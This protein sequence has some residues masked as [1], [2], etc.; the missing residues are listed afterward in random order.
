MVLL[1]K[2]PKTGHASVQQTEEMGRDTPLI[3][4]SGEGGG[5]SSQSGRRPCN[6]YTVEKG[7]DTNKDIVTPS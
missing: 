4:I 2:F 6:W 1:V 5:G 7:T 3:A